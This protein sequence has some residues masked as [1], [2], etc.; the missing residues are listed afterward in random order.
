MNLAFDALNLR[1]LWGCP[2]GPQARGSPSNIGGV[3]SIPGWGPKI[4]HALQSKK[5]IVNN[6]SNTVTHSIKT[7]KMVRIK[8]L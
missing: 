7:W 4:P 5:Q 3:G 1:C 6:R 8:N 2:G